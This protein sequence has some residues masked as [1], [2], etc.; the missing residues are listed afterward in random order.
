MQGKEVNKEKDVTGLDESTEVSDDY[1]D[2]STERRVYLD[3]DDI[4]SDSSASTRNKGLEE[5]SPLVDYMLM[6]LLGKKLIAEVEELAE[7]AMQELNERR[8]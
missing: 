2:E 1:I 8:S 3:A 5:L 7:G 4:Q 6:S